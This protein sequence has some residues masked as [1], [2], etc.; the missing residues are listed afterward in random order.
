[1]AIIAGAVI[2]GAAALS[3]S[4]SED[5]EDEAVSTMGKARDLEGKRYG[6]YR[7]DTAV[8]RQL[9]QGASEQLRSELGIGGYVPKT[10]ITTL[11]G[12]QQQ[13]EQGI[14]AVNSAAANTGSLFSGRRGMALEQVGQRTYSNAYNQYL[15]RL[16]NAS[17]TGLQSIIALGN[18]GLGSQAA[19][20]SNQMQG[21]QM[22]NAYSQQSADTMASAMSFMGGMY[23]GGGGGGMMGGSTSASGA[24]ASTAGGGMSGGSGM[25]SAFSFGGV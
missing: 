20:S 16:Q 9:G 25:A 12:Y 8:Y 7:D 15:D 23:G 4:A 19:L 3:S 5:A 13:L 6:I 2:L 22:A 1:M 21:Q 14:G 17:Q 24:G 18:A 10:D 11:P